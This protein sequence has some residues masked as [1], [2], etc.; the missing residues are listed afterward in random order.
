MKK[1]KQFMLSLLLTMSLLLMIAGV[2]YAA[3]NYIGAGQKLNTITTGVISMSFTETTN[4]ISIEKALPTTD[5][6]GKVRMNEGEYF[7]FS[8]ESTVV[9]NTNVNWEIAA[10]DITSSTAKKIDGSHIKLYLT[11][12][13]ADGT[14]TEVMAPKT[15]VTKSANGYTGRPAGM[16]SLAKGT[17]TDSFSNKYRLRMYVD[18]NY[19]PQDDG[20]DLT[21][22]I[23][24]NDYG[25]TKWKFS[26]SIYDR[27]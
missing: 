7:D 11:T 14:E 2:S 10:E 12:V 8:L 19:N 9:G 22:T 13:N 24:V 26:K 1:T 27:K 4:K 18:E 21:F 20:G 17:T 5:V 3:F 23:K 6:T 16:M 25:N 15:F